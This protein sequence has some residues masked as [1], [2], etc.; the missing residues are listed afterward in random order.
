MTSKQIF[1]SSSGR[2]TW[3]IN[4]FGGLKI[5]KNGQH[6]PLPPYRS[7]SL[8]A[9]L[10]L[11]EKLPISRER[12]GGILYSNL[13]GKKSR[14]RISDNIWLIKKYLPGFPVISTTQ[15]LSLNKETI[16]VDVNAFRNEISRTDDL[17][18]EDFINL[19]QGELLPELY[20]N[21]ILVERER[22]RSYYLRSLRSL[23]NNL[24]QE[25]KFN[26]AIAQAER[27]LREEPY[28]E[29]TV[30]MLMETYAKVGRRGAALAVYEKF[31]L[32]STEQLGF[33]PDRETKNLYESI[34]QQKTLPRQV[35]SSQEN[36]LSEPGKILEQARTNL[37]QG[38]RTLFLQM[39]AKLPRNLTSYQA[40]LRDCLKFDEKFLWEDL[41][42]AE[43]IIRKSD[44]SFPE[45][46]LREAR[47]L[48]ARQEYQ[49]QQIY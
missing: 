31:Y 7:Y 16:W 24:L 45:I 1:Y 8:L 21:W 5:T 14:G 11:Y 42:E 26:K 29:S 9:C 3:E 49:D 28:D 48:I 27:L 4:L 12:L 41:E 37:Q 18:S 30:R 40:L 47:L 15:S 43:Q 39:L 33:E 35:L 32:L 34:Y 20:D 17:L 2:F 38:E 44:I 6:L 23:I 19:Y 36:M 22:W 25:N 13:S 10:L 46:Q